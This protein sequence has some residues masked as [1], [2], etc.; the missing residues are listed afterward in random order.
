MKRRVDVYNYPFLS[1]YDEIE[2]RKRRPVLKSVAI[3]IGVISVIG[4]GGAY[5]DYRER[6]GVKDSYVPPP[7]SGTVLQGSVGT[8]EN[9]YLTQVKPEPTLES[10]NQEVQHKTKRRGKRHM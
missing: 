10:L 1:E 9:K 4:A 3:A 2:R 5:L 6:I 8:Q 7:V